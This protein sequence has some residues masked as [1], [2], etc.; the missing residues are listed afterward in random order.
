[1]DFA[2]PSGIMKRK[3][4]SMTRQEL[5]HG[6]AERQSIK[7]QKDR[8]QISNDIYLHLLTKYQQSVKQARAKQ[9]SRIIQNNHSLR[10]LF[11][12]TKSVMNPPSRP[13]LET[14]PISCIDFKKIILD[15]VENI[16]LKVTQKLSLFTTTV[17]QHLEFFCP[18]PCSNLKKSFLP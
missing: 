3:S 14:S 16:R 4:N 13:S 17:H 15:Q 10:I 8:L 6:T 9:F 7:W 2:S 11:S 12:T 5:G 1:M 18:F